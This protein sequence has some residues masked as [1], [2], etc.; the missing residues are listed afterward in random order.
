MRTLLIILV[1][2]LMAL[3]ALIAGCDDDNDQASSNIH[4]APDGVATGYDPRAAPGT[5]AP[6]GNRQNLNDNDA[7]RP[8][9]AKL[10]ADQQE[11]PQGTRQLSDADR[12]FL[13]DAVRANAAELKLAK[14]AQDK[15]TRPEVKAY[16]KTILDEHHKLNQQLMAQATRQNVDLKEQP[17]N[18]T[19]RAVDAMKDLSG[20]AF[21][22]AYVQHEIK[23]HE[24]AI[25]K[26]R[27][28]AGKVKDP[29]VLS[30]INQTLPAL[31]R[32]LEAARQLAK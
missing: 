6:D 4:A 9:A 13:L 23:A 21:D 32:H 24:Q 19:D 1:P 25:A 16:A 11:S 20:D 28:A 30:L 26:Y 27:D 7:A 17:G 5:Q 12:A 8:A 15:A 14:L 18:E 3:T 22:R 2:L 31:E 10:P 29:E